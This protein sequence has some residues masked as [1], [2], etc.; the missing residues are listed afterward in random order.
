MYKVTVLSLSCRLRVEDKIPTFAFPA[1]GLVV[2]V[3][4]VPRIGNA[5]GRFVVVVDSVVLISICDLG[6]CR[7]LDGFTVSARTTSFFTPRWP[8]PNLWSQHCSLFTLYLRTTQKKLLSNTTLIR[9]IKKRKHCV[10]FTW[11]SPWRWVSSNFLPAKWKWI[12]LSCS[13]ENTIGW[14]WKVVFE[15][16]ILK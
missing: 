1:H 3:V 9:K 12:R 6:I 10:N 14:K 11:L 4:A 2:W 15:G 5:V 16:S 13:L 7:N 8:W